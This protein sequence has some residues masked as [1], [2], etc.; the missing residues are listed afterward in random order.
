VAS[1]KSPGTSAPVAVR[2]GGGRAERVEKLL[3]GELLDSSG[4][5]YDFNLHHV[6]LVASGSEATEAVGDLASATGPAH[7]VV[8][9][10]EKQVWGWVGKGE[11]FSPEEL[12]ALASDS[13]DAIRRRDSGT[14]LAIGEPGQGLAGWRL[15]HHQAKAALAV[16]QLGPDPVVRYADVAMLA[17]ILKDELLMSSL[18]HLYLEPL[19]GGRDGG[20]ELRRTLRA[21]F[22]ADRNVSAAAAAVGVT[23]QA[24]ARRLR[25]AEERLGR[26]IGAL[27]ADL[28]IALRLEAL[29]G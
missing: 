25:S 10:G 12:E 1:R 14:R 26:P 5:A 7:L 21:Y 27:G 24:V 3:S 22:E 20:E 9:R 28:E 29:A 18:Q 13:R 4:L 6:A 17:T 16:A 19:D 2:S 11:R 8:A 23:R 15:S